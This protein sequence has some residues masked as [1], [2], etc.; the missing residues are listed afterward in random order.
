MHL[1]KLIGKLLRI[2]V[3]R[4]SHADDRASKRKIMA[5]A[6]HGGERLVAIRRSGTVAPR[7]RADPP[8]FGETH[9]RDDGFLFGMGQG[10]VAILFI[11]TGGAKRTGEPAL[12]VAA[13][14]E[15]P[16]LGQRIAG[17]VNIAA[18]GETVGNTA[19]VGRR[20][21]APPALAK[22]AAEINAQLGASRREP[23]DVAQGEVVQPLFVQRR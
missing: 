19:W 3:V 16:R 20:A 5:G 13:H 15:R 18:L 11:D 1:T 9:R 7:E 14:D 21:P 10:G 12:A 22:L 23:L 2:D 17:V 4:R 8:P 6:K